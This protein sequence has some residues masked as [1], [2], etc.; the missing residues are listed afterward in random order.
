MID[1]KH[2]FLFETVLLKYSPYSWTKSVYIYGKLGGFV[3][4][5]MPFGYAQHEFIESNRIL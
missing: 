4:F 2:K 1:L 5:T 3:S